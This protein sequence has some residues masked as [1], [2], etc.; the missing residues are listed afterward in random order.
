VFALAAPPVSGRLR[1][2]IFAASLRSL[3]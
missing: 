2:A 1:E 3:G